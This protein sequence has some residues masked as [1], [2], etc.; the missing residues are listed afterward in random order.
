MVAKSTSATPVIV[1][2]E[3]NMLDERDAPDLLRSIAASALVGGMS[4]IRARVGDEAFARM[5][6]RTRLRDPIARLVGPRAIT[7][8]ADDRRR[9]APAQTSDVQPDS[10]FLDERQLC[11]ELGISPVTATK[12]RRI[13]EGPQFI[14]VGRL[15]RYP[16]AALDAWLSERTVGRRNKV[17]G[18]SHPGPTWVLGWR[19]MV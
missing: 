7:P 1:D 15:I 14:R 16:R 6:T 3:Q 18:R 13:A 11:A 19:V 9:A 12:W 5:A 4:F 2:G 10:K 17:I 8:A